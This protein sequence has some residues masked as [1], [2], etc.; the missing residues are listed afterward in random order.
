MKYKLITFLFFISGC[1]NVNTFLEKKQFDKAEKYCLEK[2]GS[3]RSECWIDTGLYH[4]RKRSYEVARGYYFLGESRKLENRAS[5]KRGLELENSGKK[6]EAAEYY[7]W[8]G[9]KEKSKK[10]FISAAQ[11]A[12]R[13]MSYALA[14][15][16]YE[17]AGQ[18][19]KSI[20]MINSASTDYMKYGYFRIA[21]SMLKKAGYAEK[22][23]YKALALGAFRN[24]LPRLGES[25]MKAPGFKGNDRME[26][27][28]K[29]FGEPEKPAVRIISRRRP[30][31]PAIVTK[32]KQFVFA[33]DV[34]IEKYLSQ[35]RYKPALRFL[36]Q[37]DKTFI[38]SFNRA[39]YPAAA[40]RNYLAASLYNIYTKKKQQSVNYLNQIIFSKS[41]VKE[42]TYGLLWLTYVQKTKVKPTLGRLVKDKQMSSIAKYILR[43]QEKKD[44]KVNIS[45]EQIKGDAQGLDKIGATSFNL[46][47][48]FSAKTLKK[49][50]D[51]EALNADVI[52]TVST[53][54]V[55]TFDSAS[56]AYFLHLL[57]SITIRLPTLG[58]SE[59]YRESVSIKYN[60]KKGKTIELSYDESAASKIKILNTWLA[61]YTEK[62]LN[63]FFSLNMRKLLREPIPQKDHFLTDAPALK[64]KNNSDTDS[65][66]KPE[67]EKVEKKNVKKKVELIDKAPSQTSA[68]EKKNEN[69]EEKS[70]IG[71]NAELQ[72]ASAFVFRGLNLYAKDS[73]MDQHMLLAP[74]I[75]W[76]I[77][78][79]GLSIGYWGAF[80]LT[81]SNLKTNRQG[82]V[83]LESDFYVNYEKEIG[84]NKI[85]GSLQT[86]LFFFAEVPEMSMPAYL[87]PSVAYARDFNFLTAQMAI[88]YFIGIQEELRPESYFYINPSLGKSFKIAKKEST[89][90]FGYGFKLF[91]EGNTGMSNVHDVFLSFE[92][93][94]PFGW[95]YVKPSISAAWTNIEGPDMKLTDGFVVWGQVIIGG[96]K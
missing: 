57:R 33:P 39:I 35:K 87:E 48:Y 32:P 56:G 74:G 53:E 63:R 31:K 80:Q 95:W 28:K 20:E 76:S 54:P 22:D 6:S 73:Q 23:I 71:L 43:L 93:N 36:E 64:K 75:T 29:A 44:F 13:E 30:V 84:K 88:H 61:E 77:F 90:K 72:V 85:K 16:Y 18:V 3:A 2:T 91:K 86:Y 50:T 94:F 37:Y 11:N 45:F 14:A 60:I 68:P 7:L 78:E 49:F 1:T 9:D 34:I 25:L 92:M 58:I 47:Q 10:L 51:S 67:P 38:N 4:E 15:F 59:S 24:H 26:I 27:L 82:G 21:A 52:I 96:D 70:G 5:L 79:T 69:E 66:E 42:R 46:K 65:E 83:N 41:P 62:F 19:A 12:E 89:L 81:G 40:K 17:K 8:A 55:R